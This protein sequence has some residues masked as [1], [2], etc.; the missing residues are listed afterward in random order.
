LPGPKGARAGVLLEGEQV[1]GV[2]V[3]MV[4]T[5]FLFQNPFA[6]QPIILPT[7]LNPHI[8]A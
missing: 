8:A 2:R 5:P 7:P 3:A 4:D 6:V 1:P